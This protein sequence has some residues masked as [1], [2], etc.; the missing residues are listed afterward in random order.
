M[1]VTTD[2]DDKVSELQNY[3]LQDSYRASDIA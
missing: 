1:L 3:L 2:R